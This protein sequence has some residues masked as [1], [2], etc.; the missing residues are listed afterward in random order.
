MERRAKLINCFIHG[1]DFSSQHWLLKKAYAISI[2]VWAFL[3]FACLPCTTN[4]AFKT[5]VS[6]WKPGQ[7]N[8][9]NRNFVK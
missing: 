9:P 3:F 7:E 2:I 1:Q 5:K 6:E 8:F 4:T